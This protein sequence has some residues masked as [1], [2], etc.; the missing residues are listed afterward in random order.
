MQIDNRTYRTDYEKMQQVNGK[1]QL[2]EKGCGA[3]DERSTLG[4]VQEPIATL[5]SRHLRGGRTSRRDCLGL[6]RLRDLTAKAKARHG[7]RSLGFVF[8]R[9]IK[10]A[11]HIEH[12]ET[13][14]VPS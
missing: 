13:N 10:C 2:A 7:P 12:D 1:R 6:F 9:A 14:V 4:K 3:S 11:I 5:A 8:Q